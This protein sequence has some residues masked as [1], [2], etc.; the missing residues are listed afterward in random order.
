MSKNF[1]KAQYVIPA[2]GLLTLFVYTILMLSGLGNRSTSP[3]GSL[4]PGG[5]KLF[6]ELCKK[7][8][9][10]IHKWY[11]D[12]TAG[13][14]G[15]LLYLDYE[16]DH[17]HRVE[18]IKQWVKKG[19]TLIMI[20]IWGGKDPITGRTISTAPNPTLTI[21]GGGEL[22]DAYSVRHFKREEGDRVHVDSDA[23][24]LWPR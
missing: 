13:I 16:P 11:T 18:S 1:R 3:T 12:S 14:E 22:V 19:N 24:P 23:G 7:L 9:F 17:L 15:C 10:P 20:G 6:Y 5:Y 4:N 21:P 2:L 8:D